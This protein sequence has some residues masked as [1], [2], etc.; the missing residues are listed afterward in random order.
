MT[1]VMSASKRSALMSRI[2][3]SN[4]SPELKLRRVLF[5]RGFR[6]RLN[7]RSLPGRPDIVFPRDKVAVFVDGCFWHSCPRHR[8]WPT[9]RSSFW[10]E[11][12]TAN[13]SRDL[14]VSAILRGRGWLVVR[15]WEH[16]IEEDLRSAAEKVTK[17]LT[18]RTPDR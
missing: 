2:R 3:G 11:K 14:R 18:G 12:L 4:T 7:L 1:D 16:E 13:R 17:K 5:S 15:I 6:Y 9:T 8:A 10:R